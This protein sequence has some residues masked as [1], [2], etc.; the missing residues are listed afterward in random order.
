MGVV[1]LAGPGYLV[2]Q[3]DERRPQMD[4]QMDERRPTMR[5]RATLIVAV[6]TVTSVLV[7]AAPAQ[8]GGRPLSATLRGSAEV[9]VPGDPDGFGTA[10]LTVNP[11]QRRVCF[12]LTLQAITLPYVAAHIHSGAAGVAGDVVVTL[13]STGATK[14]CASGVSRRLLVDVIQHPKAYYVNVHTS[15]YPGGAL[16]GQLG[17]GW[18]SSEETTLRAKL[19]GSSEVPGPG[20]PDGKGSASITL[21]PGLGTVCFEI[22]VS[23]IMLPAAGAHIHA[24]AAGVAGPVVVTLTPPDATGASSGCLGGQASTLLSAILAS[25]SSYYVNVHTFDYPAGAVRGQLSS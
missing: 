21:N 14:G 3:M 4:E 5:I 24:G 23:R 20:D 6:L 10:S 13:S 19:R 11:G 16:R 18:A 2:R 7:V 8:A 12:E 25:P 9:P 1:L 17:K 22:S 15:D